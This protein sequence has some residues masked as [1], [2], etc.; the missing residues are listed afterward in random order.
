MPPSTF[1][2]DEVLAR[3]A[4]FLVEEASAPA[5]IEKRFFRFLLSPT[6]QTGGYCPFVCPAPLLGPTRILPVLRF[7]IPSFLC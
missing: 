4:C 2:A 7:T 6:R 1:I 3:L 5:G